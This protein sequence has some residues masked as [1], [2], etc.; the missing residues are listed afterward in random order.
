MKEEIKMPAVLQ[1][2]EQNAA[3]LAPSISPAA[4]FTSLCESEEE[5]ELE[6][7]RY[8]LSCIF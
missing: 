3:E 7:Q 6:V 1:I 2:L 8:V 4:T 5:R